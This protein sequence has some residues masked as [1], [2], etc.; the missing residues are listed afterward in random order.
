MRCAFDDD[1]LRAGDLCRHVVDAAL[2]A[3]VVGAPDEQGRHSDLLE[4]LHHLRVALRKD[5][6]SGERETLRRALVR[7][8]R[9]DLDTLAEAVEAALFEALCVARGE[10]VPA[11][12]SVVLAVA[13]AGVAEDQCAHHLRMR[14]LE[15]ERDV[16]A[17]RQA[18]DD[19]LLDAEVPQQRRHILDRELLGV[20]VL[21]RWAIGAAVAAH[22]PGDDT[23]LAPRLELR[24]PHLQRR[25]VRVRE[26]HGGAVVRTVLLVVDVDAVEFDEGHGGSVSM[27]R[28]RSE[29]RRALATLAQTAE[30]RGI[31]ARVAA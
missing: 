17:E 5:A 18:A 4:M 13:G 1:L 31:I 25:G 20:V 19:G 9:V 16:A 23:Q 28:V 22:V 7:A 2:V 21:R 14:E 27:R 30:D 6:A 3:R 11:L 8:R 24:F 29:D 15:L 10:V 12:A 26:Q